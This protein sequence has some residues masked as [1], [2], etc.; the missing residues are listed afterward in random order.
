MKSTAEGLAQLLRPEIP[1]GL[2]LV[3][4]G[5]RAAGREVPECALCHRN[6]VS[7]GEPDA[8]CQVLLEEAAQ[9]SERL[10]V[11]SPRQQLSGMTG[12][13]PR[14]RPQL[15]RHQAA[16][17]TSPSQAGYSSPTGRNETLCL[18]VRSS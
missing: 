2:H 17:G 8:R 4:G 7:W 13:D 16:L 14:V 10:T 9:R 6:G 3:R 5:G 11:T 15:S 18:P 12:G 1:R